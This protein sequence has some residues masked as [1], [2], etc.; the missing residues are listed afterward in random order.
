M[1]YTLECWLCVWLS[2]ELGQESANDCV[3]SCN[4]SGDSGYLV[5]FRMGRRKREVMGRALTPCLLINTGMLG[6][7]CK[8]KQKLGQADT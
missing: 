7:A 1:A 2:L 8:T 6:F 4:S 3:L 5:Q